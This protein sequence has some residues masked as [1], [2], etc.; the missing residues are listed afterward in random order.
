MGW[1]QKLFGQDP[2]TSEA[3][4]EEKAK[5]HRSK[6]HSRKVRE[7]EKEL[8]GRS[9]D[10]FTWGSVGVNLNQSTIRKEMSTR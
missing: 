10:R 8:S 9:N 1:L 3:K 5:K 6:E 4:R 7:R 2:A